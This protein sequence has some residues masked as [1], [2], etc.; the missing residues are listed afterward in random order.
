MPLQLLGDV[1]LADHADQPVGL[2]ARQAA[3]RLEAV[4]LFLD[5]RHTRLARG[6]ER[7]WIR[8]RFTAACAHLGTEVGERAGRLTVGWG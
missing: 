5:F 1:G 3:V 6:E 4:P 8:E 7:E 2:D